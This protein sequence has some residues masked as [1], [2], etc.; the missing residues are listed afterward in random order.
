MKT[1]IQAEL[2]RLWKEQAK[3]RR[4]EVFGGFSAAERSSY[5]A[6]AE[7]IHVLESELNS[8]MR[9]E[10]SDPTTSAERQMARWNAGAE[11]DTPQRDARQPYRSRETNS[12]KAFVDSSASDR[13]TKR[14]TD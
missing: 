8:A 5:E 1:D 11:T 10:V 3:A 12:S 2:A 7:R 9:E 13:E 6:R 4:D 14:Q